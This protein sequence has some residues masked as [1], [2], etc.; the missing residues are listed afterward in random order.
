MHQYI[1]AFGYVVM[2]LLTWLMSAHRMRFPWRVV[3]G[4]SLLQVVFA[5]LTLRTAWGRNFFEKAGQCFNTLMDFVDKGNVTVFGE[6]FRDHYF[7]FKVLPTIIFFSALM[8]VLY[9]LG[10]MQFVVRILG[11]IMQV[12][13]RTSGAESLSAAAN[14]FVGQTEA[15][16]VVRPYVARMTRSELMAIMVGGFATVAG[17]VMALYVGWGIDAGHLMTASVISAPAGLM[18]AKIL[19]PEVEIPETLGLSEHAMPRTTSN[20][21]EAATIGASDGLKLALN[22]G[23]MLIAFIGLVA[24]VDY[25]L[26]HGSV[27][28]FESLGHKD[29][30]PLTMARILGVVFSPIAWLMGV[31]WK[32]CQTV[33]YLL[34]LKMVATELVAYSQ[35]DILDGNEATGVAATLSQRSIVISTYALCGFANFASIGIQIGGI[36]AMAPERR[37]D[38]TQLGMRAML[39]GTLACCM[40]ACIAG[41]LIS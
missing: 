30:Q 32:E 19:Q 16:L 39:G 10:I 13:L 29:W 18:I 17:G 24:M 15:P 2:I 12:T 21:I 37:L 9:H 1:A 40:T 14:I 26:T 5:W 23:A 3:L 41:I 25:G 35:L 7:A 4:G 33:G 20:L 36:G 8:S 6:N 22:V 11:Y 34:G 31:E 38:L 28:A 27:W